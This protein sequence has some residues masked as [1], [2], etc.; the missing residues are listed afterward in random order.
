MTKQE[1]KRIY[2]AACGSRRL[3]PQ[4][5]ELNAWIKALLHFEL[6]DVQAAIDAWNVDP[7]LDRDGQR[8]SKWLPSIAEL[9][10]FVHSAYNTRVAR[11][12]ELRELW[13]WECLV[14]GHRMSGF[15]A[16]G[17]DTKRFCRSIY[18]PIGS[19]I[20]LTR[21]A[22]CGHEMTA[23]KF[24]SCDEAESKRRGEAA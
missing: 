3:V 9:L 4:V 21:G 15:L 7:A 14:C 12:S 11:V 23:T 13:D 1:L 18:G 22:I 24:E 5:D 10:P 2:D 17:A 20:V 19:R 6:R 16:A 8:R